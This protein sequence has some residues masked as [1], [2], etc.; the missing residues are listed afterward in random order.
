[1]RIVYIGPFG[2]TPKSTMKARAWPLARALVAMG[3]H[4]KLVMPPWHTNETA[5]VWQD[6]GVEFE[7]VAISRLPLLGYLLTSLRLVRSALAFRP[8]VVHCFKPTAYSGLVAL[9]L[10]GRKKLGLK[11]RLVVDEDDWE[12]SGGWNELGGYPWFMKRFFSWQE[13][14]GL[15]HCDAVTVASRA[16]QTIT[17]S[18]GV[19]PK[20][21]YYLPNG[22][23]PFLPSAHVFHNEPAINVIETPI[24]LLYT[25]FVEF[26]IERLVD[27]WNMIQEEMPSARLLVVGKALF[28]EIDEK[29]DKLLGTELASSVIRLGWKPQS[30]LPA[31]FMRA[32]IALFPCDDTLVNRCKC[33]AKLTDLLSAGIPVVADAVGQNYEYIRDGQSGLLVLA[34]DSRAMAEAA[35]MLLRDDKMRFQLG[36]AANQ[37]MAERF[38]WDKLANVALKAYGAKL[39]P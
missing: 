17:W 4:V 31:Y 21:V 3:H 36:Q 18:H 33:S 2:L 34:G 24:V 35:L 10:W 11:V 30:E 27:I 20:K 9:I 29:L 12:G 23:V 5:R 39:S 15:M 22:A 38:A 7:Y 25:R 13:N 1:M 37:F 26:Q 32:T 28:P 16:L 14:W 6:A 8:Q 19:A